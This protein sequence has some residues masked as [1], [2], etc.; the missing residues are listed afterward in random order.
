MVITAGVVTFTLG[1][2][3]YGSVLKILRNFLF[4][5]DERVQV[6]EAMSYLTLHLFD[7]KGPTGL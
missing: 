5:P 2:M 3:N 7:N 1:Q 6:D 4:T